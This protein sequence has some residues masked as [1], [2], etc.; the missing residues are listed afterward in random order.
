LHFLWLFSWSVLPP[1]SHSPQH[2]SGSRCNR[3]GD[4]YHG[5][6]FVLKVHSIHPMCVFSSFPQLQTQTKPTPRGNSSS[7][8]GD[9][10]LHMH[11][12]TCG[13]RLV[14]SRVLGYTGQRPR[15]VLLPPLFIM[16]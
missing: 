7:I 14:R 15:S 8:A 6:P 16:T 2:S 13:D 12:W 5:L 1:C 11:I 3:V 4:T 10:K 9:S